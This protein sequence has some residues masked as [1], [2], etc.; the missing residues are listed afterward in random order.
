MNKNRLV[1]TLSLSLTLIALSLVGYTAS[2]SFG[3]GLQV[4]VSL[5]DNPPV[6][7]NNVTSVPSGSQYSP[8]NSYQFNITWIGSEHVFFE[9][10][11]TLNASEAGTLTNYSYPNVTNSSLV[12][13]IVLNDLPVQTFVYRWIANDTSANWN[14]TDNFTFVINKSDN[15]VSLYFNGTQ[16]SNRTYSYPNIVNATATSAGGTVYF[17]RNGTHISNGTSPQSEQI[18]LVNNTY[19]YKANAT[20]NENYTD[21]TTGIT[22]YA[23]VNKGALNLSIAASSTSVTYPTETNVTGTESNN[24][25][26]DVVYELWRDAT[27]VDNTDPYQEVTTLDAGTYTYRFNSTGGN[28]WTADPTGVT[29]TLTVSGS[30]FT[31]GGG[32]GTI[33]TVTKITR[34]EG[35]A[36]VSIESIKANGTSNITIVKTEG[37]AIRKLS[38]NV[39]NAVSGV[40]IRILKLSGLPSTISHDIDG[41]VF[42]YINIEKEN[43]DDEDINKTIIRFAINKTWLSDN[44]VNS[45]NISLYRWEDYRWNELPTSNVSQDAFEVYYEATSPG[46]SVFAIGTSGGTTE[47]TEEGCAESWS[48]TE[49]TVCTNATQTRT[50]TDANN[51]GTT[52]SKPAESQQC[53]SLVPEIKVEELPITTIVAVA[54]LV[55]VAVGSLIFL[56]SKGKLSFLSKEKEEDE[57]EREYFY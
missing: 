12:F 30:T 40:K 8:G 24:G 15:P 42:N 20:G 17:Y 18:L 43:I 28:N 46:F 48:C 56:K 36:N 35:K 7:L 49:W 32:S 3:F 33:P 38:I 54:L 52:S 10:N 6:W 29:L 22:Y 47:I 5:T 26:G 27:L 55:V 45:T 31:P 14:S 39:L 25:D 50:C 21:N 19:P 53:Q 2:D 44:N 37:M 51:C 4:S 9:S 34:E 16:N 1:L 57:E 23:I 41:K 11:Y 13:S